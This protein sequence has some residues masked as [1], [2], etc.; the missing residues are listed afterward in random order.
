[1]SKLIEG[2]LRTKTGEEL[3]RAYASYCR[4]SGDDFA[5]HQPTEEDDERGDRLWDE[6]L[7][8]LNE[9]ALK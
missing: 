5:I 1:M 6:I 3:L 7:R 8:R 4:W 9:W 2:D